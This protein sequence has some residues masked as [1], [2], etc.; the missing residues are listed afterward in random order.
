MTPGPTRMEVLVANTIDYFD[1]YRALL[2]IEDKVEGFYMNR[3]KPYWTRDGYVC[4]TVYGWGGS[5][6][7]IPITKEEAAAFAKRLGGK[8]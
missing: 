3:S 4:R 5:A 2:N 1:D 7:G 6:D 8:L